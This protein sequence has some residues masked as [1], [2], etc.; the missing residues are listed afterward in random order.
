MFEILVSSVLV[1]G[2]LAEYQPFKMPLL[3]FTDQTQGFLLVLNRTAI[4][5][6]GVLRT[7]LIRVAIVLR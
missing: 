5:P 7:S 4:V 1:L 6:I 3:C 2:Q